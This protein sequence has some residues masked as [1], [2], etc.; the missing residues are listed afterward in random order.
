MCF[1]CRVF[2]LIKPWTVKHTKTQQPQPKN[3]TPHQQKNYQL[4]AT[5]LKPEEIEGVRQMFAD[6][7]S[8][9]SGAISFEELRRGLAARGAAVTEAELRR[10]MD[11][12][13]LDGNQTLDFQEFLTATVYLGKLERREQLLAAFQAFDAD[14]SGYITEDELMSV[15]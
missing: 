10:I 3:P 6:L 12:V 4:I 15:S 1:V 5:T 7:D 11:Q 8:D 14:G 13:D 2:G 9:G